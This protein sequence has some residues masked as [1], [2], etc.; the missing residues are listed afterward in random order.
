V[1]SSYWD[2][3]Y[4]FQSQAPVLKKNIGKSSIENL[5][6]NTI[7]PFLFV[8]GKH[9]GNN[10]KCELAILLLASIAPE[11]NSVTQFWKSIGIKAIDALQSQSLIELKNNHCAAKKCLQCAIGH[12]IIKNN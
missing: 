11:K 1:A 8:Y 10:H 4:N 9:Y 2:T 5:I 6:I 7:V 3:H 12:F